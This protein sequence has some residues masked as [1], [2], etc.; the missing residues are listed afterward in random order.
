MGLKLTRRRLVAALAAGAPA[1]AQVGTAP[2]GDANEA[3]KQLR[4][5][6]AAIAKVPLP[7]SVEPAF[8]FR[9]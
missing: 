5:S 6:A 8:S 9:V 7:R 4:E 2:T 1:A 3:Q